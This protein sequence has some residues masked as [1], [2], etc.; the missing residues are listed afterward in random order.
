MIPSSFRAHVCAQ[1]D[2]SYRH[3]Y[4]AVFSV[5]VQTCVL[6]YHPRPRPWIVNGSDWTTRPSSGPPQRTLHFI[7]KKASNANFG[8]SSR[9]TIGPWSATT[10][11]IIQPR[12]WLVWP[13]KWLSGYR[14][15]SGSSFKSVSQIISFQLEMKL[16]R[17]VWDFSR[18]C[19]LDPARQRNGT[20]LPRSHREAARLF[21]KA[22]VRKELAGAD[23]ERRR[24][25]I[26]HRG[27]CFKAGPSSS[28]P[29]SKDQCLTKSCGL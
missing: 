13:E 18:G 14:W 4:H 2:R 3:G 9:T 15:M 26:S 20:V 28:L 10:R 16:E 12:P 22:D 21:L 19:H 23:L 6:A 5:C 8:T 11:D 1:Q 24:K 27:M 7:W 29:S 17:E 25:Y